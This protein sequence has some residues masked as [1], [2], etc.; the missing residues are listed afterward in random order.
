M[1]EL[2]KHFKESYQAFCENKNRVQDKREV[3]VLENQFIYEAKEEGKSND[4]E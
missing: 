4:Y 1:S 2:L 3:V